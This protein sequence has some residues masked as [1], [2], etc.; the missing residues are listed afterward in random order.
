LE[1]VLAARPVDPLHLVKVE[2]AGF[3]WKIVE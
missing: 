1:F 3:F 2:S